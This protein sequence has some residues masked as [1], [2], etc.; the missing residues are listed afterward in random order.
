MRT[1]D[2]IGGVITSALRMSRQHVIYAAIFSGFIN[3]LYLVPSIY[4][5][6]VY[7]RVV[8]TRGLGT[9]TLLTLLLAVSLAVFAL[10]D[11]LRM[12]LLRRM[13]VRLERIAAPAILKGALSASTA[14]IALR[15]QAV[16]DLDTLRSIL[17]GP[18][19]LALFDAPWAPIYLIVCGLLHPF[20]GLFALFCCIVLALLTYLNERATKDGIL[21]VSSL[22]TE[23]F[24]MQEYAFRTSE[25]SRAL[26]MS[27]AM[28]RHQLR[29]RAG[30]LHVQGG[31]T[32]TSSRYMA[33]T[34]FMRMLFQSLALGLG[35]WLAVDGLISAGAI[36]AASLI[37]GRALAPIEQI[38]G[39]TKNVMNAQAAYRNLKS[40]D[41][42]LGLEGPRTKLPAP[43]GHLSVE[44]VSVATPARDKVILKNISFTAS[45]GELI[46]LVGPSGSGKSTLLRVLAGAL[47]PTQGQV[48][49]DNALHSDWDPDEL[50]RHIGYLPQEP[51][52]M[53][54]TVRDNISRLLAWDATP[55]MME[56]LDVRIVEAAKIAAA[57]DIIMRMP[58]AYETELGQNAG[59]LSAGQ[60]QTVALARALFDWPTLVLLDEPNAH[61]DSKGEAQL[62][63]TLM[64]L[65]RRQSTIIVSSH[66]TSIL[67]VADRVLLL[68]DG[69]AETVN[70]REGALA[71]RGEPGQIPQPGPDGTVTDQQGTPDGGPQGGPPQGQP[72]QKP[73]PQEGQDGGR[74]DS[75]AN[76]GTES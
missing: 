45:P 49:I 25:V 4:M 61:L 28:V 19:I 60:Q 52:L 55:E 24:R 2:G 5:L 22:S 36:F 63:E 7:G 16:R 65:K 47:E 38:L 56:G 12:Q 40:I 26:G 21:E 66:R 44:N 72:G 27:R 43:L 73:R 11:L 32:R 20:L 76:I 9:L 58:R 23:S 69:V 54:F 34:K 30:I 17:V 64:E 39:A 46:A 41:K 59:G 14:P 15:S 8:P 68:Q 48:R 57:H 51:T 50:G 18:A 37:L 6:Q 42:L 1:D 53:P 13:S 3:I 29:S 75:P 31:V 35:A 10:L 33:L 67:R 74:G 71:P 62:L 70:H